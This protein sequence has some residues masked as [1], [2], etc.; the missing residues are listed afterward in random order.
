METLF[1]DVQIR[2]Q[3]VLAVMRDGASVNKAANRNLLVFM[4]QLIDLTC[5]AHTLD[6]VRLHFNTPAVML[7]DFGQ[8]LVRL[9]SSSW[10]A[11]AALEGKNKSG[12]EVGL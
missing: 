12:C 9:F 8:S 10:T 11:P 1:T 4:P 6:N 3:Q 2:G 7:D 5:F